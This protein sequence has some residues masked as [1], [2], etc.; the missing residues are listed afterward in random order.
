MVACCSGSPGAGRSWAVKLARPGGALALVGLVVEAAWLG[1]AQLLA[2]VRGSGAR[3]RPGRGATCVTGAG[4]GT[5]LSRA[6]RAARLRRRQPHP[7]HRAALGV[8]FV[9]FA[10][11][12]NVVRVLRPR[13]QEWLLTDNAA[14]LLADGGITISVPPEVTDS[15]LPFDE[16]SA[17]LV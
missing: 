10:V 15:A 14:A 13:W 16:S 17:Q 9:Y 1:A 8:G 4:R 6:D 3:H 2:T 12:E 5:L 7:Q 11:V